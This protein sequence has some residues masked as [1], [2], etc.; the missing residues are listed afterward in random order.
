[1]TAV[2]SLNEELQFEQPDEISDSH[3]ANKKTM[4]PDDN[5]F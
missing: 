2:D 1:M 5:G 3:S 4:I